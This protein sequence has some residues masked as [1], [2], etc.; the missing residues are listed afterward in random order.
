MNAIKAGEEKALRDF[1]D[2]QN[3]EQWDLERIERGL[4]HPCEGCEERCT[5]KC[6]FYGVRHTLKEM[7]EP[8]LHPIFSGILNQFFKEG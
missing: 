6:R 2:A 3:A 8:M 7:K 4:P 1:M 5:G